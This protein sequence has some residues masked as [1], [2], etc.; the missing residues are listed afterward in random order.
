MIWGKQQAT[1]E[2]FARI[3]KSAADTLLGFNEPNKS[4]QANMTVQQAIDLWPQMMATGK[5]LGSPATTTGGTLGEDSWLDRFME[6]ASA[7]NYRV[8]FIAVHYYSDNPDVSAFKAFLEAVHD[9]YQKP[10]WVTEWALVDWANPDRFS[11]QQIAAFAHAATEMMDNLAFVERHAWFAAYTGGDGWHINTELLDD[12]RKL[13]AVGNVFVDLTLSVNETLSGGSGNDTL[14]GRAG[15]DTLFGRVGA[16]ILDGGDGNDILYGGAGNDTLRGGPGDDLLFGEAGVDSLNGGGGNDTYYVDNSGDK[17]LEANGAGTGIDTVRTTVSFSVVSQFVENVVLLG[18]GSISAIGN[19]LNNTITGNSGNNTIDG[20]GG[21]DTMIGG[22]GN[23][24]YYVDNAL[25]KT[26]EANVV[27]ADTV[28]TTVSKVFVDQFVEVIRLAGSANI[29]TTGNG[30]ANTIVGNGA[31]NAMNGREGADVMTGGFG[32]DSFVFNTALGG[33]NVD[34]ITDFK[35]ADDRIV[36]DDAI[37]TALAPGA[38]SANAFRSNATGLAQ[39]A[40]DRIIYETDTGRIFYDSNGN[41]AG[42]NFLFADLASGLA[43]TNADFH[44]A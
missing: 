25:D 23:D 30:L 39:D 15:N 31:N 8:D 36:L 18:A 5:R 6:Q 35:P 37:F 34:R 3:A 28:Y 38:L 21:I 10:I 13:T 4:D 42:G 7:K 44:L 22:A 26:I 24:T 27:G 17:V 20:R 14:Y 40:D 9:Q 43:V 16:D 11:P 19:N 29:N 41:A 2:T 33:G 1:A 12:Q 32:N